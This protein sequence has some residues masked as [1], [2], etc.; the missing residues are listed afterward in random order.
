MV[1]LGS[2]VALIESL[3]YRVQ[4]NAPNSCCA[5]QPKAVPESLQLMAAVKRNTALRIWSK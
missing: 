5:G 1:H 4:D 3:A 2:S